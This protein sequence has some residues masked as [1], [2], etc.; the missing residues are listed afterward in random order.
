[1]ILSFDCKDTQELFESER[2]RRFSNIGRVA[3]RKLIAVNA[4]ERLGDLIVPP[5]NELKALEGRW[6]GWHAIRINDQWRIVFRW[7]NKGPAGV[8]IRD[9]H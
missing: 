7:T 8:A 2:N 9:Y 1:M 6:R 5:G 3:L 4:A